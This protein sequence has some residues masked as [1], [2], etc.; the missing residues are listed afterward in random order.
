MTDT[1][2]IAAKAV[3]MYAETHPRPIHVTQRQAADMLDLSVATICRMVRAGILTL[4]GFGLIPT[5]QIDYILANSPKFPR[6]SR[7]A[8]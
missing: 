6:Q 1:L 4:N 5:S 7:K 8:A 3:Q 2:A